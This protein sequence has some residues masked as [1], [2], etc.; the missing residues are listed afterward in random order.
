MPIINALELGTADSE[1]QYPTSVTPT[2][3]SAAPKVS[4][5]S[6]F[7]QSDFAKAIAF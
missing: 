4:R 7:A 3:F 2:P 1:M 5:I 6:V